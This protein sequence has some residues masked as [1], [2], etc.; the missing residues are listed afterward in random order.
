[1]ITCK[2]HKSKLLLI[3]KYFYTI[4]VSS[5]GVPYFSAPALGN[6]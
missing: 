3:H 4:K 2:Y 5:P 1:M 6:Q